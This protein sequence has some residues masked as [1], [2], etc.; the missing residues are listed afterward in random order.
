M[1]TLQEINIFP[2]IYIYVYILCPQDFFVY[3]QETAKHGWEIYVKFNVWEIM[4]TL[5]T[6]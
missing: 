6:Q 2:V 5:L 1:L 4:S 3:Y